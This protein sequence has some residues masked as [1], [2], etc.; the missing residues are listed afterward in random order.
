MNILTVDDD[1]VI[2][3][4]LAEILKSE[5]TWTITDA[6][7]GEVAWQM[8]DSGLHVD[9]CM[10]DNVMPRLTGIELLKRMRNDT[11]FAKIPVMLVT[12]NRDRSLVIEA[13]QLKVSA[14]IL[15]PFDASRV[16][17]QVKEIAAKLPQRSQRANEVLEDPEKVIDRLKIDYRRYL[18][19]LDIF[20]EDMNAGIED[21]KRSIEGSDILAAFSRLDSMKGACVTLGA[22]RFRNAADQINQMDD[23]SL[24]RLSDACE[25]LRKFRDELSVKIK[26]K[27]LANGSQQNGEEAEGPNIH[28]RNE[29]LLVEDKPAIVRQLKENL[30]SNS[31][32]FTH[33]E[34][35]REVTNYVMQGTPGLIIMSLSLPKEEAFEII[36]FLRA[37]AKTRKV[38]VFGLSI[39]TA[40]LEHRKA[41]EAG[42]TAVITKPIDFDELKKRIMK[43][44]NIEASSGA[45]RISNDQLVITLEDFSES[46]YVDEI[47]RELKKSAPEAVDN[48]C[49]KM[50]VDASA[51]TT[52]NPDL[53]KLFIDAQKEAEENSINAE[54]L[55]TPEIEKGCKTYP[56]LED[57]VIV[58]NTVEVK[59]QS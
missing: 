43:I 54:F 15:K 21:I 8:L 53:Y 1:P 24:G 29:I 5:P 35:S 40:T 23:T 45:I 58:S 2:R 4:T 20:I 42:F 51:I 6:D 33:V 13:I 52:D 39:K 9:M 14:F 18:V 34:S 50:L 48:G 36:R 28:E 16:I 37:N 11:R 27:G 3:R 10:L 7:D 17:R 25:D 41:E 49:S 22:N 55:L 32:R 26:E 44:F 46:A 30:T 19:M 59:A 47:L 12:L 38:P 57:I 31:W 56:D